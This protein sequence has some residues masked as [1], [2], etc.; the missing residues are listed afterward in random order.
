MEQRQETSRSLE[1]C[2]EA[3]PPRVR[4][5]RDFTAPQ[6]LKEVAHPLHPEIYSLPNLHSA[7]QRAGRAGSK[8]MMLTIIEHFSGANEDFDIPEEI[9]TY[10][11]LTQLFKHMHI[12]VHGAADKFKT[13]MPPKYDD[14]GHYALE[15]AP[16]VINGVTYPSHPHLCMKRDQNRTV[17]MAIEDL[18]THHAWVTVIVPQLLITQG[19]RCVQREE[20]LLLEALLEPVRRARSRSDGWLF[21]DDLEGHQGRPWC[22]HARHLGQLHNAHQE[23]ACRLSSE[24]SRRRVAWPAGRHLGCWQ[25]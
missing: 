14:D 12:Q 9:T 13:R 18:P 24:V 16:A 4:K 23:A 11:M 2:P 3:L 17:P 21:S 7:S 15:W 22:S 1:A 8:T 25:R 6:L 20:F 19:A 10:P 5:L